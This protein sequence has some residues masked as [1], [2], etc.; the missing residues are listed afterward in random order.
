MPGIATLVDADGEHVRRVFV[1]RFPYTILFAETED[2]YVVPSVSHNRGS[3]EHWR[4]RA[5]RPAEP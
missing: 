4:Q 2:Q 3:D 1:R 5:R